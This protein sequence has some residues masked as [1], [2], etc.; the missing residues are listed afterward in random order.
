MTPELVLRSAKDEAK[1]KQT[2]DAMD[3]VDFGEDAMDEDDVAW[4]GRPK[5][6]S[7]STKKET[8]PNG[9]VPKRRTVQ[10]TRPRMMEKVLLSL[11][12]ECLRAGI[13]LPWQ[14]VANR[15]CPGTSK[16]ALLQRLVKVR[17]RMIAEGHLVPPPLHKRPAME[18]RK[19]RGFIRDPTK[20]NPYAIRAVGW[21]ERINDRKESLTIPG[22]YW[23]A[24]NYRKHDKS[25][26]SHR[27][28]AE[29]NGHAG[30]A[31]KAATKAKKPKSGVKKRASSGRALA[32]SKDD[33]EPAASLRKKSRASRH[34]QSVDYTSDEASKLESGG[35][36]DASEYFEELPSKKRKGP[37]GRYITPAANL[38]VKLKLSS[39]LLRKF[40]PGESKA[41]G[42]MG[43]VKLKLSSELLR[44]FQAAESRATGLS[45]LVEDDHDGSNVGQYPGKDNDQEMMGMVGGEFGDAGEAGTIDRAVPNVGEFD[46]QSEGLSNPEDPLKD[47]VPED[48]DF[49]SNGFNDVIDELI[50]NYQSNA[51]ELRVDSGNTV[52][53][54]LSQDQAE[55]VTA[56]TPHTSILDSDDVQIEWNKFIN[57]MSDSDDVNQQSQ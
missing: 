5:V 36:S 48:P 27:K 30:G 41:P 44:R 17:S 7:P 46:I 35:E 55:D 18:D 28:R 29:E 13:E 38:L 56:T 16:D 20:D 22:V 25:F 40:P 57:G 49:S 12:Y 23:G 4:D 3:G 19:L 39:G 32:S 54:N 1:V 15:V 8:H 34:V 43:I 47:F 45:Q 9:R 21:A 6:I 11:Q 33:Y 37:G 10:W 51:D 31:S 50:A 14:K 24:G 53:M 52:P 42:L 2:P 26:Q